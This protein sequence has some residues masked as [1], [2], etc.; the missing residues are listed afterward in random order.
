M[1]L[2]YSLGTARTV[3]HVQ[4]ASGFNCLEFIDSSQTPEDGVACYEHDHTQGPACSISCGAAT[5]V[6]NYFVR[7]PVIAGAMGEGGSEQEGQTATCMLNGLDELLAAA[8]VPQEELCVMAGT[9]SNPV[10]S[11]LKAIRSTSPCQLGCS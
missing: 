6:R 3:I 2:L 9:C 5:V 11:N 7:V 4:V 8:G 1:P 10:N